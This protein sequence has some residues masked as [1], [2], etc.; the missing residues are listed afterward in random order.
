MGIAIFN[1][2][3][4]TMDIKNILVIKAVMETVDMTVITA[5]DINVKGDSHNVQPSWTL[6]KQVRELR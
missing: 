1:V 4:D 3:M 5:T 2:V 6:R